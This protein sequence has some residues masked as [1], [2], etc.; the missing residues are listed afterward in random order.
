MVG[1]DPGMIG[2][3]ALQAAAEDSS[4]ESGSVTVHYLMLVDHLALHTK[5]FFPRELKMAH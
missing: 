1:G 4:P 2:V 5:Y 3:A